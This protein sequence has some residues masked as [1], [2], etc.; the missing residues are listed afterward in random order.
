MPESGASDLRSSTSSTVTR[1]RPSLLSPPPPPDVGAAPGAFSV[2][3]GGFVAAARS[4]HAERGLAGFLL[5][6]GPRVAMYGPSCAVSWVAYESCKKLLL[7]A[8]GSGGA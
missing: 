5:G 8:R 7:Q 3:Y 2:R 4:I 6:V 1:R